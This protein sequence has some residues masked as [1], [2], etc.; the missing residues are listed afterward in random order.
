MAD[1]SNAPLAARFGADMR[2][3]VAQLSDLGYDATYFRRM[4]GDHGPVE[5]ARRL[6]LDPVPSYGL[7][8]LKELGRL[9]M[10]VE[11]WVLL[12]WYEPLFPPDVREQ[13]ENKLA[14][15]GIDVATELA[16]LVRRQTPP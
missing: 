11:M 9:D 2:R 1:T 4:L 16:G 5:A 10:S 12:P 3:G 6:A 15:L 13:A 14:A 8:R 7:W